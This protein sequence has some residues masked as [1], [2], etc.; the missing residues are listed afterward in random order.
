MTND[1]CGKIRAAR[2]LPDPAA[3]YD[4]NGLDSATAL[5]GQC[6][7][8]SRTGGPGASL[9]ASLGGP[10]GYPLP[11]P[12]GQQY[13][14]AVLPGGRRPPPAEEGTVRGRLRTLAA[15]SPPAI[16]AAPS[17]STGT[18]TPPPPVPSSP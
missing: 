4:S 18:S 16:L 7:R 6:I 10:P 11:Q 2:S 9:R 1:R 14:P 12:A 17:A 5:S 3:V 13:A 15:P 8:A